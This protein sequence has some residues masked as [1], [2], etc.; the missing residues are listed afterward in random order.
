MAQTV[1]QTTQMEVVMSS[2]VH[3]QDFLKLLLDF[4]LGDSNALGRLLCLCSLIT[5]LPNLEGV[6]GMKGS[7]QN[8]WALNILIS[9]Y[10]IGSEK[11]DHF[12]V[13]SMPLNPGILLGFVHDPEC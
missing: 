11:R 3:C 6:C 8:A 10:V 12:E 4:P 2:M 5:C 13:K 9:L 7:G 1:T